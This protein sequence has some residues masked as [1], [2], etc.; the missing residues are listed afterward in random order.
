[1]ENY[2]FHIRNFEFENSDIRI[3][4]KGGPKEAAQEALQDS[5]NKE[6]QFKLILDKLAFS[7]IGFHYESV[8][9]SLKAQGNLGKI[10]IWT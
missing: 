9:D 4:R 6:T 8:F 3:I 2:F 5:V 10:R 1:L 7:N